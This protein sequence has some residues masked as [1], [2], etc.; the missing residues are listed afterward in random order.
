MCSIRDVL[1]GNYVS[2]DGEQEKEEQMKVYSCSE[3]DFPQLHENLIV[4]QTSKYSQNSGHGKM[5]HGV[6]M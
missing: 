5:M 3:S 6:L 2:D 4:K 1:S